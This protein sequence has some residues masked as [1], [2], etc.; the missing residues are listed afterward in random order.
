[1]P[2]RSAK[3][4][5]TDGELGGEK[6]HLQDSSAQRL[7]DLPDSEDCNAT[8]Q[9]MT[10]RTGQCESLRAWKLTSRS[11]AKKERKE[12]HPEKTEVEN[13]VQIKGL[14]LVI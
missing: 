14:A 2:L 11:P 12:R 13:T 4:K 7:L 10:C 6:A 1:M 8:C 3:T 5:S 9:L